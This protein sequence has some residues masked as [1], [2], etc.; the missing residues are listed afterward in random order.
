[1]I[2]LCYNIGTKQKGRCIMQKVRLFVCGDMTIIDIGSS[3]ISNFHST[4]YREV[5]ANVVSVDKRVCTFAD[6][7]VMVSYDIT[8][9][10]RNPYRTTCSKFSLNE[11]N[12][13]KVKWIE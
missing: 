1:M 8:T 6:G 9:D 4:C 7:D 11:E 13:T 2:A 10:Y 5:I 12:F 3:P